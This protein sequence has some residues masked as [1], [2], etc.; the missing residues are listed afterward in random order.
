MRAEA[1]A[2]ALSCREC[3]H[4]FQHVFGRQIQHGFRHVARLH[5]DGHAQTLGRIYHYVHFLHPI[6]AGIVGFQPDVRPRDHGRD[7]LRVHFFQLT[8]QFVVIQP[9]IEHPKI[10]T[11][12]G[13]WRIM[14]N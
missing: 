14:E 7:A 1:L 8:H 3:A 11:T 10:G 6:R 13:I 2:L 12:A 5:E 4:H 9:I